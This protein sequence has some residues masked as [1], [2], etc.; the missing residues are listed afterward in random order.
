MKKVM[1]YPLILCLGFLMSCK[2][3]EGNFYAASPI[4]LEDG[5]VIAKG[6]YKAEIKAK[7][8]SKL[9]VNLKTATSED[10]FT[11]EFIDGVRVPSQDGPFSYKAFENNQNL[12]IAGRLNTINSRSDL[13]RER[14]TCSYTIHLP[15][16]NCRRVCRMGRNNRRICNRVCSPTYRVVNG[17]QEVDYYVE[18]VTKELLLQTYAANGSNNGDFRGSQSESFERYEYVGQCRR[19]W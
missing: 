2:K 12:D 18:T 10:K 8:D 17:W 13:R 14:R 16:R 1:Y 3:F 7:G 5:K 15:H 4:Q 6:N 9:K 11:I 19:R